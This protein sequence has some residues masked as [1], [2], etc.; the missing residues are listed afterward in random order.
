MFWY[1]VTIQEGPNVRH[2]FGTSPLREE[3]FGEQ[4]AG[5]AFVRLDNVLYRDNVGYKDWKEWDPI[6]E[7]RVYLNPKFIL[8][9][10]PI[11]RDPREPEPK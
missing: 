5:T 4:L 8:A 2:F 7:P 3:E 9:V 6:V 1:A 10:M 11:S